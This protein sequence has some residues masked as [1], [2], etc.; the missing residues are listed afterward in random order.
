MKMPGI[1][2][3]LAV[4]LL[5]VVG[6]S[7]AAPA[8]AQQGG[9]LA[10][11]NLQVADGNSPGAVAVSWDGVE[12]A[13]FYRIG[14]VASDRIA[15]ALAAGRDWQD[16]F[17]FADV[18]NLG[19]TAHRLT[20]LAPGGQYAFIIG[21]IDV[22]YGAARWSEWAYLTLAEA[23]AT[24]CPIDG[25]GPTA[26]P[27]PT[28]TP[29]ATPGPAGTP[30]PMPTPAPPAPTP[31]PPAPTPTPSPTLTLTPTPTP[32]PQPAPAG[33]GDYDYDADQDGLIEVASL[34][35]LAAIRADLNGDGVSPAPA[36]AAAFPDAMPG[37]GCPDAGCTG[38]E[39]V[40]DLDFDTNGNGEADAGDAY[41]NDGAGWIP[42]GNPAHKFTSD[43]DGNNH[44]IANLYI[45]R[46]YAD[47]YY[48]VGLFGD[49]LSSSIKQVRLTSATVSGG[50]SVRAFAGAAVG[51]LVGLSDHAR[52]SDSHTTGSVFGSTFVGGLV[53]YSYG[54]TISGSYVMSSVSSGSD[55]V[56]GL[57][58]HVGNVTI[59]DSYATGS[60][61]GDDAVGGLV[62]SCFECTI[63]NGYTTGNVSGD[64]RVGGLVGSSSYAD[65]SG[66][67][68]TGDV[69]GDDRVGGL[70]GSSSYAD[71]SGSYAT[72]DVSGD[73]HVGGLVGSSSYAHINGSYATGDVSGDDR[74]GGLVGSS[75][76]RS[77]LPNT[78]NS[79][80]AT[81]SVV[82]KD[83]GIGG[84]VGW[85]TG[86][87]ITASYSI[88]R[89]STSG[90]TFLIGG[91]VGV[92]GEMIT[93]SYWDTQAIGQV[94]NNHGVGKTTAEL[95]SPTGYTGIYA[96]WN[97]DLDGDG[98]G[99]DPWDFGDA[100]QYPVLKYGGL[101]VDAQRR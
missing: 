26:T 3:G 52:I 96:E 73:D 41:W 60:V 14:W 53:G 12:D 51:T 72:G 90:D 59:T 7:L 44:T 83:D 47:D 71:I 64:D 23:P 28:P 62:G 99:D 43:F 20:D 25:E 94:S 11:V 57:V 49:V 17:A 79:S 10:P 33:T 84:L 74:V 50:A 67:Y 98:D 77:R 5:V 97:L 15:A 63:S 54:G 29:G 95:Q 16:A 8:R 61:S 65:I 37:M 82:G 42:I 21:S 55:Y 2:L 78:V 48:N 22:R 34:A 24:S 92:G 35:Q 75:Y 93:A 13:A 6:V 9:L 38:Y 1:A 40:A 27:A 69:S 76:A 89:V 80:Y 31:A 45:D 4:A 88:G 68:A 30:A 86:G 58:G 100:D 46:S 19:Q 101:D 36:Y 56:G 85:D 32:A 18:A 91:L 70:V 39:L 87:T 66:N 81:G